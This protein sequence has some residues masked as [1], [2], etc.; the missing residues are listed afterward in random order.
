MTP[1]ALADQATVEDEIAALSELK[2]RRRTLSSGT[3]LLRD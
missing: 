2:H 1:N 3:R